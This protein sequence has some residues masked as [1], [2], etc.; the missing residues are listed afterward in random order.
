MKNSLHPSGSLTPKPFDVIFTGGKGEP[1]SLP[2]ILMQPFGDP[3]AFISNR[4]FSHVSIVLEEKFAL[5]AVPMEDAPEIGTFSGS[6]LEAGV[7]M[8]P[9]L[10][11]VVPAWKNGNSFSV[12]RSRSAHSVDQSEFDFQ[13]KAILELFASEYSLKGFRDT[14]ESKLKQIH[15]P[16][17]EALK[18]RFDWSS[19]PKNLAA[20]LVEPDV[21]ESLEKAIPGYRFPFQNTSY[22]CSRLVAELL[23]RAGLFCFDTD[24][25]HV[26]PTG[27]LVRLE[28]TPTGMRLPTRIMEIAHW[29]RRRSHPLRRADCPMPLQWSGS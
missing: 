16:G 27:L 12:F 19:P 1:S 15:V 6:E 26:S 10:N 7:R 17:L 8:I 2:N 24:V 13:S 23:Q 9:V 21:K 28:E 22:F 18:R 5:E 20:L 29:R 14:I 3:K 4:R 25:D 11:F